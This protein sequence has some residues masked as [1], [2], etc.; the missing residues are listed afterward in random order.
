MSKEAAI[1][2]ARSIGTI[3][4]SLSGLITRT[5]D[6]LISSFALGRSSLPFGRG[7]LVLAIVTS[8]I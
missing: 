5:F 2:R 8:V 7:L 4:C 1:S 6:D 3:S